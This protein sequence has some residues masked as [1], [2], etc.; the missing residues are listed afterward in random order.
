MAHIDQP[1]SDYEPH[2]FP[3][4][5]LPV[6]KLR[7]HAE[8]F[9][10][11]ECL[12]SLSMS[13][14]RADAISQ[15][16]EVGETSSLYEREQV[17]HPAHLLRF[18]DSLIAA[19]VDLPPWMHVGSVLRHDGLVHWDECISARARV[20]HAFERK[21]HDFVQLDVLLLGEDGSPRLRVQ[22]YTAIYRPAFV[23]VTLD[24]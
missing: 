19:N 15:L 13:I 12:G 11:G 14:T 1:V 20:M 18:A 6:P 9:S 21:G 17:V 22:P 4:R 24:T 3:E 16:T 23:D 2:H 8:S 7:A 10:P 5:A